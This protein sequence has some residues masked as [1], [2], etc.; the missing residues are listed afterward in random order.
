MSNIAV[1]GI[2]AMLVR[3]THFHDHERFDVRAYNFHRSRV[4]TDFWRDRGLP[5]Y[6]IGCSPVGLP[7][8]RAAYQL[9]RQE[10]P[11]VVL[12]YGMRAGGSIRPAAWL[13]RV[14]LVLTGLLGIEPFRRWYHT[15]LELGTMPLAD[16]YVANCYAVKDWFIQHQHLPTGKVD[17]I[18]DGI[19]AETYR[20]ENVS[21]AE[22]AAFRRQ[23]GLGPEHVVV[24]SVANLRAAKGYNYL[25]EAAARL[26]DVL[27]NLRYV[28]VGADC[29]DGQI[30]RQAKAAGVGDQ[31]IFTGSRKDIPV[32][33]KAGHIFALPSNYEGLPVS[34][35][36]AMACGLPVVASNVGGVAEL[37]DAGVS[38]FLMAK[39][40]VA[41]L[42]GN[43]RRLAS[44]EALR[45]SMGQAGRGRVD[46]K[47][48]IRRM[49]RE[50]EDYYIKHLRAQGRLPEGF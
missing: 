43:L 25:V 21:D 27:P 46:D 15:A 50:Y 7:M 33:L 22:V 9:F 2:E 5:G 19:D 48:A 49:V 47:F 18:Y 42:A 20:P 11:D 6:G 16:R 12:I 41:A 37:V 34:L 38:G 44:D 45:R 26:K 3:L 30:Q 13:A 32:I 8:A 36:E 40:D 10:R 29:L 4:T 31:F 35:Q 1:G 28:C 17:V 23:F 14:P 24:I 39:G